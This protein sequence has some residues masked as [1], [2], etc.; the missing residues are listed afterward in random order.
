MITADGTE[1]IQDPAL[2]FPAGTL[3]TTVDFGQIFPFWGK[4]MFV[5]SATTNLSQRI[6]KLLVQLPAPVTFILSQ[7]APPIKVE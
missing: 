1:F 2:V 3:K 7:H 6:A 5:V 4:L